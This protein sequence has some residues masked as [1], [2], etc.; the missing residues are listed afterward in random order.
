MN[1]HDSE[2]LVSVLS[3]EGYVS[4]DRVE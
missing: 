3:A 4:T 1:V 2:Q